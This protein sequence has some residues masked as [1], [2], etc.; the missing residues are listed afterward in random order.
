MDPKYNLAMEAIRAM[1]K[2]PGGRLPTIHNDAL[3]GGG[4]SVKVNG[5]GLSH[6][7]HAGDVLDKLGYKTQA[8]KTP[9]PAFG[10]S[11]GRWRLHIFAD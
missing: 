9:G 3:K 2:K 1:V 10:P 5:W 4:R 11:A 7:A 6:I 8:I